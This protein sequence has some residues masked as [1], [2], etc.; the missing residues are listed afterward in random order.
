MQTTMMSAKCNYISA[1]NRPKC[2]THKHTNIHS[3]E[4]NK[5]HNDIYLLYIQNVKTFL[6]IIIKIALMTFS[7]LRR[8][9]ILGI[10]KV[11]L[12]LV[13]ETVGGLPDALE[14]L[15]EIQKRKKGL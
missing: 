6:V 14:N 8:K 4:K 3:G 13:K 7:F 2:C 5:N 9:T 11:G 1:E 15:K 10:G 12:R